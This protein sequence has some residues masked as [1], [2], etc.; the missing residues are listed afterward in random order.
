[1]PDRSMFL[2]RA[3]RVTTYRLRGL[4]GQVL[5][6]GGVLGQRQVA[7]DQRG[8]RAQRIDLQEFGLLEFIAR[9]LAGVVGLADPFQHDMRGQRAGT[10]HVVQFH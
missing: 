10:G 6:D 9:Q 2:A 3:Q 4:F 8:D 7:V 5:E 1:M